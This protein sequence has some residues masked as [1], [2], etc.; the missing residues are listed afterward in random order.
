L[1][2]LHDAL[3]L[4]RSLGKGI[5]LCPGKTFVPIYRNHV[6]AQIRPAARMRS[7]FGWRSEI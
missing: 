7:D 3:E 5:R 2:P 4:A 6:I 1:R